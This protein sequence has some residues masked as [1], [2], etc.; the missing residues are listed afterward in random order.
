M[1]LPALALFALL[2]LAISCGSREPAPAPAPIE[3]TVTGCA[4]AKDLYF[5]DVGS[6]HGV[7]V[8]QLF[9]VV[10]GGQEIAWLSA[11]AIEDDSTGCHELIDRR[12]K[13]IEK[14]DRVRS[15]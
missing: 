5:L 2:P 15:K 4:P 7:K 10:R 6:R 13:T 12:Y 3:G 8:G 14:G 1:R 11:D 9:V